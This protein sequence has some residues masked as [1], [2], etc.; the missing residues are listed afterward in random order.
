[1]PV[2]AD[3]LS[4]WADKLEWVGRRHVQEDDFEDLADLRR[5]LHEVWLC[6]VREEI[7]RG[8]EGTRALIDTR[9]MKNRELRSW[10]E[11][12]VTPALKGLDTVARLNK[13]LPPAPSGSEKKP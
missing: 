2:D 12:G 8:T 13:L 4:R 5:E 3:T 11:D 7:D 10:V 6:T 1:V 9:A